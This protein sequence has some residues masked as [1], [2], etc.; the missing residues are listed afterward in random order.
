MSSIVEK[1]KLGS[2]DALEGSSNYR[3]WK[4][5]MKMVLLVKDLWDVVDGTEVKPSGDKEAAAWTKK[6]QK[7][8]A[9]ISLSLS[10]TEQ[11]NILECTTAKEAWDVLEK[12][13]EGKG[14]NR[15][16]LLMEQLFKMN[17]EDY[18][19]GDMKYYLRALKTKFSE[20]AA[21]GIKLDED[22]K[23]G[24][25]FN[26]LSTKFRYLVVTLEQQ[27]LDFDELAARLIEEARRFPGGAR[28][29]S[30]I[31]SDYPGSVGMMAARRGGRDNLKCYYCGQFGHVKATCEVRK[32]R[33]E[34][35]GDGKDADNMSGNN[36]R[37]Q[38]SSAAHIAF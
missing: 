3:T 38:A 14:R 26:G 5:S 17:M 31:E 8:L 22:I 11:Q 6:S 36:G 4:Y 1:D 25:I 21:I 29:S 24:I 35:Y 9:Y 23:L 18:D 7:A 19:G 13:Y 16:W 2:V 32:Y 28:G 12:L 20:L 30:G 27:D 10:S 33:L 37:L 34:K 15:K